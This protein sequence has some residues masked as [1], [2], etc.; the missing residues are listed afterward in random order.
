[1]EGNQH[2]APGLEHA[3]YCQ[4][5]LSMKTFRNKKRLSQN[6]ALSLAKLGRYHLTQI[7]AAIQKGRAASSSYCLIISE[8]SGVGI[9]HIHMCGF[10]FYE[11]TWSVYLFLMLRSMH[12]NKELFVL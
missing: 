7:G 8:D 5:P 9:G 2:S 1:M 12:I 4:T 6:D 10:Y 11:I 3:D